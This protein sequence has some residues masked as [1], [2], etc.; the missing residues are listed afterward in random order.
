MSDSERQIEVFASTWDAFE[1]GDRERVR[2]LADEAVHPDCEFAPLL[3]GV[4]GRTY[5]G[6][7]G[8]VELLEEW[9]E[10]FSPRY[11]DRQFEQPRDDMVL[12][13]CR[14]KLQ[15]RESGVG[16][17]R[18]I[19]VLGEFDGDLLRRIRSYDSRA[20]AL[21]AADASA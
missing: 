4:D 6:P 17:D 2:S 18:E 7:E 20:T 9:L 15:G 13:S 19:A 12:A 5:R 21:E 3:I 14:L 16:I 8:M 11:L 1:S 10:T